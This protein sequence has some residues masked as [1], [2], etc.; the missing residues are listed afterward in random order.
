[1]KKL[2]FRISEYGGTFYIEYANGEPAT[3]KGY[4]SRKSA[5]RAFNKYNENCH[6]GNGELVK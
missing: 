4:A 1:M 2:E 6:F 3:M 5:E